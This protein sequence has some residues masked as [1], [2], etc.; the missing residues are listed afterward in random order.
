MQHAPS[1]SSTGAGLATTEPDSVLDPPR[2]DVAKRRRPEEP[3]RRDDGH[4][5]TTDDAPLVPDLVECAVPTGGRV[6]VLGNVLLSANPDDAD[7]AATAEL[8]RTIDRFTGPGALV[9]A[10]DCFDLLGPGRLDP[11][12][13]LARHPRLA[14]ALE[15]FAACDDHQLI[16]VPGDRDS[17][18]AWHK[19]AV[20]ALQRRIGADVALAVDVVIGTGAGERRVR[21]E[22][23]NRFDPT[24]AFDDP[25]DP[26]ESPLGHHV[27]REL[28]PMLRRPSAEWLQGIELLSD[29]REVPTF[30]SSRLCY[31]RVA[32]WCGW[33]VV[34]LLVAFALLISCIGLYQS[35]ATDAARAVR[36][37]AAGFGLGGAGLLVL[38]GL[39]SALWWWSLRGPLESMSLDSLVGHDHH[40]NDP[41]RAAT[42]RLVAD[43]YTGFISAHSRSAELANFND[44]FYA[45]AGTVG[46]VLERRPG[47]FGLLDAYGVGR[48]VSW[49]ELEGGADLHV[50]LHLRYQAVPSTTFVERLCTKP[51]AVG[52]AQSAVVSEWPGGQP[53]PPL[54]SANDRTR[55]R[56]ISAAAV[57]AV[58]FVDLVS[59]ITPPLRG[60]LLA[61]DRFVPLAVSEAAAALVVLAGLGLLLLARG[62]RRGQRHAWMAAVALLWSS[63]FLNVVKGLDLEEAVLA[64][65]IGLLL[66]A[67]QRH[68]RV[69]VDDR[70]T[71][72]ALLMLL[73]G[74]AIALVAGLVAVEVFHGRAPRPS[75]GTAAQGLVERMMGMRHT[76]LPDRVDDFLAPTLFAV[77]VGLV[78]TAGW[79]LFRPVLGHRLAPTAPEA[80]ENARR[81][82]ERYGT[83]TLAYFALRDDKRW[84]FW[85]DTAVA[86][87]V[88]NGVALVSPDPVGPVHERR[89]AWFAFREYADEHGWPVAVMGASEEWLPVYHASGMREMYVGDEAVADVRRF[90]LEGGRNKSLRQAV[91]RIAKY[92]Y[93]M[94]FFDPLEVPPDLEADLRA[95]MAESRRGE[96]E[97]GFSMT[98]GRVFDRRDRG[99][100]LAVCFGP[101][102]RPAAFCQYVPAPG[103]RG[104]SLDLMR[105]SEGDHPNGLTDFVVVKTM[106]Y[107]R[108]RGM[109]GLGLNFA[110]MRAVLAGERG[111]GLTPRVERWFFQKM[112]DSM[113]IESLWHYNG[114]FDPDWVP[115]FA[116]YESPEHVLSAAFALAKAESWWEIP[117]IGRLF[118]PKPCPERETA[119]S[120]VGDCA[121][122]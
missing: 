59:A 119:S 5:T 16:V 122:D 55:A 100:L 85:G 107:L 72:R 1:Q 3:P 50:R 45:N 109:V 79:L 31:R 6:L 40:P 88:L 32:R 4:D 30:L 38:V 34:P 106:D 35:G 121:S 29:R 82:V 105:R 108:D 64:G 112:S 77:T 44:G 104:Y 111:E 39:V 46:A 25:R 91:N 84:W 58:G 89:R 53:W 14:G 28:V 8:S 18:L 65:A 96:V 86:Y 113:Q 80:E 115:R 49:L 83:D 71:R 51:A 93:R 103:V 12:P 81:I 56:R 9:L 97:R 63:F 7:E 62:L 99:L 92:G 2:A 110:T 102:D 101:D 19:P 66:L 24:N 33:L 94:E 76:H 13:A 69:Q 36:I 11:G 116:V 74:L 120:A 47:R 117:V 70:S 10:G 68:F 90:T 43:G 27:V 22:H 42:H 41:A 98:L 17:C 95:L 21:V 78:A 87:A 57:A 15:A 75:V 26:G 52:E 67:N 23:G 114:K 20:T 118:Q 61:I 73:G 48:Q 60:R 54:K 37:W